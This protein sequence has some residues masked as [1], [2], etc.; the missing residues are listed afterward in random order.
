MKKRPSAAVRRVALVALCAS[1][2]AAACSFPDV[3]F[4]GAGGDGTTGSDAS[5]DSTTG[6]GSVG[7]DTGGGDEGVPGTDAPVGDGPR[8]ADVG[9]E[10]GADVGAE[11]G[12]DAGADGAPV[13]SGPDTGSAPDAA[14]TGAPK[15]SGSVTDGP[16]CDCAASQMYATG[17]TCT[18][19]LGICAGKQGFMTT[20]ACGESADFFTCASGLAS[21]TQDDLGPRV[22]QCQ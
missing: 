13:D 6:E 9:A 17:I 18:G 3:S 19:I 21:C 15:D 7:F 22:Q 4:E 2:L 16:N 20:P 14:D 8:A 5:Q 11:T 10:T 1:S 12:V